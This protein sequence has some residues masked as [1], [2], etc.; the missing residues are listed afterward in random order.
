MVPGTPPPVSQ[1][2]LPGALCAHPAVLWGTTMRLT[3]HLHV[4]GT[5][6][7]I[8][9]TT[10]S[11]QVSTYQFFQALACTLKPSQLYSNFVLYMYYP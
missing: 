11:A 9:R 5:V 4:Q 7:G 1:L 6:H 8:L 3:P 10:H 2:I